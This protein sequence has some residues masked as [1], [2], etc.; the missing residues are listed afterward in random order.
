[1]AEGDLAIALGEVQVTDVEVRPV[2]EHRV[3][4]PGALGEVLDVLVA[5][6]LPR[7]GGACAL[8]G[9]AVVVGCT[10]TA[11]D[12]TVR[13][14][15]QGEGGHAVRIGGDQRRLA[16]VPHLQQLRRGSGAHQPGVDHPGELDAGNVA[17]GAPVAAEVPHGLV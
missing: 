11:E 5:A 3:E 14:R 16:R 10:H 8:A 15:R 1:A 12:G 17:G 13:L 4:D 7:R 2:H 9:H 6:V